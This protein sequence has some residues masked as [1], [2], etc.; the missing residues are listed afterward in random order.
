MPEKSRS[1]V[2]RLCHRLRLGSGWELICHAQKMYLYGI[3]PCTG[4]L[5]FGYVCLLS[6]LLRG[7]HR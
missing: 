2:S 6:Y 5:A 4:G 1:W 3:A 7:G